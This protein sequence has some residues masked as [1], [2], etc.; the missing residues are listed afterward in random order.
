M[1][2]KNIKYVAAAM[3]LTAGM[4]SCEDFLDRPVEDNYNTE[5]YYT[6]DASC[7]RGVNYLYNSPWYDFQRGFI[8]IG[9]VMSGNMYWGSSPY[10]N[11]S[12][13]GTDQ[14]LVNMSYSLWAEIGHANTVYNSIK[15]SSASESVKNQ[16]MGECL[17]WK[18]MAYFFLVRT[19]GD[20]P[21][22]HDNSVNLAAG[23][24]N[25][26]HKVQKAD[27][28]EYILMTL[29][30]A[31]EL[32]P[33]EKS[34]TGRIDYYSAEGLYAKVLLTAA[35][36]TGSLN[37]DYLQRASAASL[38][39]IQNSG[40]Q[41]MENYEDIFRG[42]N[43]NSDESLIAWRWTVGSHWTCQNTQQSDLMPE[44]FDEFG[45]CWGGWGGPS[46]DLE[47]AF[48]YAYQKTPGDD[49]T[50]VIGNP[51]NRVDTD[52]RRKA[53]MMG[54]GDVYEYFWR[55]HDLGGGKKGFDILRFFYD[56]TYNS[57][58]TG[59]FQG[60]CGV[61]NV[62]HAYG[63]NA[64]HE[65]ECGM[66]AA[67]MSY[68]VATHILRLADVYLVHAE[69]EV[70]QGK[71]TSKTALD[72]FNA[73]RWR[74]VKS[75]VDKTSLTFDDIWKERRLEFAGEGDRWYDYVRRA[76]YD[77]NACIAE[78]KAQ[79]RNALWNADTVYKQYYESGNSTWDDSQFQY[80]Q[81]TPAPNVTANSFSLPYPTEDVALNP[82][83][84][85]N[86]EP[87]HV[88]VRSTYSY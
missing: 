5:N 6:D 66:S 43:N 30:K 55:D 22:V 74:S 51:S 54:A 37:G 60:P 14:D 48:G 79:Y 50:I 26:L 82:N 9:E 38:D 15:G 76:Y 58:A 87:D 21:I 1:K 47:M 61:Q 32:L 28:Y 65:A 88:D 16:C 73:V 86:V 10:M 81:D 19:F 67:R 29:E 2:L 75:A 13:N 59:Q 56:N 34:T 23:D 8:K 57:A 69:A 40:R 70:L 36:V 17:T 80:D 52:V 31:M 33:K 84:G 20:V 3:L 49:A 77:V 35:G 42:S 27:V 41:L 46:V 72:A 7:V 12:V 62:K 18:A 45:D 39:V 25:D 44:G 83:L 68:A 4:T 85:S 24:Y 64:D 63:N 53:T 78:L 11:F 71:N